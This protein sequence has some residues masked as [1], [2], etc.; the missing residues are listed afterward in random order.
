MQPPEELVTK[1]M[2]NVFSALNY[3]H[4]RKVIHRDIKPGNVFVVKT[5]SGEVEKAV[6]GDY[7]LARPLDK[8]CQV[9]QTRVG[10][11]CYCS[12]EIVAAEPYTYKTDIFSAGAM[13]YELMTLERPF[14][15]KE[16]TDRQIFKAILNVDPM[17]RMDVL[18]QGKYNSGL[19]RI[20]GSCLMKHESGRPSAFD[21]LTTLSSHLTRYVRINHIPV[22]PPSNK[23]GVSPVRCRSPQKSPVSPS[24]SP[25]KEVPANTNA[26]SDARTEYA[27][28]KY[29]DP[30]KTDK[31]ETDCSPARLVAVLQKEFSSDL[32]SPLLSL[33]DNNAEVYA[34]VKVLTITR[35]GDLH[36]LENAM[37][38]VLLALSPTAPVQKAVELVSQDFKNIDG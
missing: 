37:F 35:K 32:D 7:G 19:I 18:C 38:K 9:I 3:S 4:S 10:T 34:L 36:A 17:P 23:N 11:P 30:N 22:F 26:T 31:G 15:K 28:R 8:T 14:W 16:Y 33:L 27:Q 12:P 20:V 13:F 2:A 25:Q 1:L 21:I 6:L 29:D 24:K 5:K